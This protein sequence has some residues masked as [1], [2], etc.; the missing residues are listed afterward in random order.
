M[1]T[2]P[3]TLFRLLLGM[4]LLVAPVTHVLANEIWITPAEEASEKKVGNWAATKKG[5]THFSFA[6]PDDMTSFVSAKVVLISK[7]D[8]T[9]SYDLYLSRSQD[10]FPQDVATGALE[11]LGPEVLYKNE[12]REI[13]VSAIFPEPTPGIDYLTLRF[14]AKKLG[15]KTKDERRKRRRARAREATQLKC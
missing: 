1:N 6:I 11:N 2:N 8:T 4:T 14:L 13:D 5:D 10:G 7:K 9:I 12:L 15:G 3:Q